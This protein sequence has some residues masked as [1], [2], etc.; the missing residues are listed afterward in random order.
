MP[1][2][3]PAPAV[4]SGGVPVGWHA[5]DWVAPEGSLTFFAVGDAGEA[6]EELHAMAAAMAHYGNTVA[7]PAFVLLLGD[8]MVRR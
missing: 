4:P 8:N 2:P 5:S 7:P 6:T 3:P 1:T